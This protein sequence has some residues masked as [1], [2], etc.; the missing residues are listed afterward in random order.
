[1][2]AFI[3]QVGHRID[4]FVYQGHFNAFPCRVG[5]IDK[6]FLGPSL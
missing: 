3:P 5:H 2:T 4:K 1:M 6:R